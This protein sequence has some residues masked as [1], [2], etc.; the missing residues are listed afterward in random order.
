MTKNSHLRSL[1][2]APLLL[3]LAS[4]CDMPKKSRFD[5]V[6]GIDVCQLITAVEAE[7]ILGPLESTVPGSTSGTGIAGEC[8]WSF[9]V[10]ATGGKGTLYAMMSTRASAPHA[11]PLEG[12]FDISQSEV[13][14]SL[15]AAPWKMEDLGDKAFLYQTR[16][17]DHS[18]MWLL[19]SETLFVLRMM[20]GSAGQLEEFAR[21]L[22]RE[23]EPKE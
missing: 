14:V 3:V 5:E 23:L 10:L 6:A 19:Q 7:H 17:P 8:T 22:S 21:A 9:K 16:Q 2:L 12:Y 11:P 15:G 18:E 1:A 4:A 13:E 20:G